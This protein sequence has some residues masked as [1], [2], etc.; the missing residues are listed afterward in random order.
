MI[1]RTTAA[2]RASVRKFFVKFPKPFFWT[3]TFKQQLPIP[4]ARERWKKFCDALL[5]Y[6]RL[7]D[8]TQTIVGIRVFELHPGGHGLHIHCLIN[9]RIPILTVRR[10]AETWGFWWIDVV[11]AH[12][13]EGAAEYLGKY[14]SKSARPEALKGAR[15]WASWGKW[16]H[17]RCK[18]MV[19]QSECCEAFK[20]RRKLVQA[21]HKCNQLLGIPSRLETNLE[22]FVHAQCHVIKVMQGKSRPLLPGMWFFIEMEKEI[23][24]TWD[25]WDGE[26]SELSESHY[27]RNPRPQWAK[28][29]AIA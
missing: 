22:T 27:K 19:L 5:H 24:K 14:L 7:S 26:W 29:V 8:G 15:L 6:G 4:V 12:S 17:S 11:P 28:T 3:F 16:G 1:N 20:Q 25:D 13:G 2:F 10:L 21:E 18:D 9:R 23:P